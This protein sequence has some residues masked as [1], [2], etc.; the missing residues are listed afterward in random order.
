MVKKSH[1]VRNLAHRGAS[2][3]APEN[4]LAAFRVAEQLGADGF[5][6]D[7]Q[8]TR[9][10]VPVVIHD[11]TLNRT[12]NGRGLVIEHT[13]AEIRALDAGSWY[14]RAFAGEKIPTLAEVIAA[15]GGRLFLNI[16][17]KNSYLDMPDLEAKTIQLIRAAN[18]Q[19][20]VLISSFHHGSMQRFHQMAPDIPTGLLYDCCIVDVVA[21]AKRLG[22]SAIHPY[23]ST[24]RAAE[25]EE[26]HRNGL[27]VNVWTVNEPQEMQKMITLPVDAIIT[28]TPER[29]RQVLD[30]SGN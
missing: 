8:V 10:G 3:H 16:E 18:I 20:R 22:A 5:E 25:V 9:D 23:Y 2:G 28:N 19:N 13:L 12:T 30:S 7:V 26:A 1:H 17:L 15:F 24:V 11:E 27:A 6:L 4:T 29:L 21:Y 14:G